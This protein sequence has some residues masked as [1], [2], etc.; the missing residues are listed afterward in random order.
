MILLLAAAGLL[1]IL[2]VIAVLHPSGVKDGAE[3]IPTM[4]GF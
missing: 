4:F 1:A 2:F 3:Y